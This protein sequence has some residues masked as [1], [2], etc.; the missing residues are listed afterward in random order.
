MS[1]STINSSNPCLASYYQQRRQD[2]DALASAVPS[3][4]ISAPQQ[5]L[6]TLRQD[7]CTHTGGGA[8]GSTPSGYPQYSL[9]SILDQIQSGGR[10]QPSSDWRGR[11]DER[12]GAAR[13]SSPSSWRRRL[14]EFDRLFEQRPALLIGRSHR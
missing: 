4:N 14:G 12:P 6:N 5:A 1:V 11:S 9:A 8:S 10:I 13:R 7:A 2:L 3:G